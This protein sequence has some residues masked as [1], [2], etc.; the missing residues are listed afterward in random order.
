M[1]DGPWKL[2]KPYVTKNKIAGNSDAPH[3]L[4]HLEDDPH[5]ATDLAAKHHERLR[6]MRDALDAWCHEVENDR[7]RQP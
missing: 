1:R 4:Y 2:V 3:E 7:R 5:E 6:T